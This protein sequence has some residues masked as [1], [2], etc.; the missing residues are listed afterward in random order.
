MATDKATHYCTI[1][2]AQWVRWED[3]HWSL[4]SASC[5]PCCDNVPMGDQIAPISEAM[6]IWQTC[7]KG[8]CHRHEACQYTPCLSRTAAMDALIADSADLLDDHP[9][10]SKPVDVS[11]TA[12]MRDKPASADAMGEVERVANALANADLDGP[13]PDDYW[14]S[15]ATAA[16]SAMSPAGEVE[17]RGYDR[18]IA[19]VVA[20]LR[21]MADWHDKHD[22]GLSGFDRFAQ[23]DREAAN[24]IEAGEHK[25]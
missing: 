5:G 18:A 12:N 7:R 15:L 14:T 16:L 13:D 21:K 17:Q 3:G 24:A 6:T 11:E 2:N 9:L 19:E 25:P 23:E 1:C 4:C 8:S 10:T 20:W 22:D